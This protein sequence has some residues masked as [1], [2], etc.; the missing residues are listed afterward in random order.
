MTAD[1][2]RKYGHSK[3]GKKEGKS[4]SGCFGVRNLK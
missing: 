1:R 4:F 3:G 2:V